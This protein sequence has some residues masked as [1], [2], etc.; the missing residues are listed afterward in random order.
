MR[1]SS[2][3]DQP[4][5]G[6]LLV[7]VILRCATTPRMPV[8]RPFHSRTDYANDP[9]PRGDDHQRDLV[10]RGDPRLPAFCPLAYLDALS[11]PGITDSPLLGKPQLGPS[12]G[13]I[14]V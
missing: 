4:Q 8:T 9:L 7:L 6:A 2:R 5:G 10:Y 3:I 14:T 11:Q 12:I 13:S 1:P